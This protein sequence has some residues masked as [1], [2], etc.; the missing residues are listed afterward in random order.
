MRMSRRSAEVHEEHTGIGKAVDNDVVDV[1]VGVQGV[2]GHGHN[3]LL[4][5]SSNRSV[6]STET[7]FRG[8]P[9]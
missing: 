2:D 1:K 8:T 4:L 9:L 6:V 3:Y 7:E 5:C